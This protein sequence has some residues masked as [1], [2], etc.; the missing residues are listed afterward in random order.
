MPRDPLFHTI[1]AT[2]VEKSGGRNDNLLVR[3]RED[4]RK[5]LADTLSRQHIDIAQLTVVDDGDGFR[6]L[7]PAGI[8]SHAMLDPFLSRLGIE[9]RAHRE[10]AST[11]NRLRLRVALHL[12]L[13]YPEAAGSYT[14]TPLKDCARLLD[15]PAGRELLADNPTA[16]M[17]VLLTEAFH[18]A[19]VA[20]GTSLNPDAFRRIPVQVKE[21]DEYGWAYVPGATLPPEAPRASEKPPPSGGG[22]SIN[23]HGHTNNIGT[24]IGGN[25]YG[26]A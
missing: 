3:M 20:G 5:M 16:D 4:L 6:L 9:L 10:A 22:S 17:V 24:V 1:L 25:Q 7:V 18:R 21:T 11:A 19:V 13:L 14:G 26:R 2:D 15:A 8:P 12:G 23:I